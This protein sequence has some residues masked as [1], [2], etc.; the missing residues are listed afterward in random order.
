MKRLPECVQV[1]FILYEPLSEPNDKGIVKCYHSALLS[2]IAN[3]VHLIF[4]N[5][6]DSADPSKITRAD[7]KSNR[8][9][10]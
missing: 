6:Q 3:N 10:I 7:N 9:V 2:T 8:T 4:T 5:N 1:A